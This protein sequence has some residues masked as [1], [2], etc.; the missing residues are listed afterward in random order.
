MTSVTGCL[1]KM[2]DCTALAYVEGRSK[3]DLES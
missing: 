3:I 1:F 2:V